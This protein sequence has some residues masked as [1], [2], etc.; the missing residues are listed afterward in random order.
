[1]PV[2]GLLMLLKLSYS[3]KT[4]D[5]HH[6][7]FKEVHGLWCHLVVGDATLTAPAECTLTGPINRRVGR[8]YLRNRRIP[9]I[10]DSRV[11]HPKSIWIDYKAVEFCSYDKLSLAN[12]P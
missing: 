11:G 7:Q 3:T 9:T 10:E 4:V 1:M 8:F 6:L 5:V 2:A 12:L